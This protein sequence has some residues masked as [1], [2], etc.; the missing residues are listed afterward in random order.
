LCTTV[1]TLTGPVSPYSTWRRSLP[2]TLREPFSTLSPAT[3][4]FIPDG[5]GFLT[6]PQKLLPQLLVWAQLFH[7]CLIVFY[8]SQSRAIQ[9]CKHNS[10]AT[11]YLKWHEASLSVTNDSCTI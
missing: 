3:I 6:S 4:S 5:P 1:T 9:K 10:S 2:S 11:Y 7:F 8:Q